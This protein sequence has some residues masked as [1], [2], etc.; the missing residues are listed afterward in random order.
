MSEALPAA[1]GRS[2]L[3]SVL[4]EAGITHSLYGAD[5]EKLVSV[6]ADQRT[7]QHGSRTVSCV[8]KSLSQRQVASLA[9]LSI[10]QAPS[11]LCFWLMS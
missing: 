5:V 3:Q 8:E 10:C 7:A 4:V 6:T 11:L 9:T 1:E 2:T